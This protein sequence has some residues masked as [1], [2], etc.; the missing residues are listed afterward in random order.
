MQGDINSFNVLEVN[1]DDDLPDQFVE[2]ERSS[3]ASNG[4]RNPVQ[5]TNHERESEHDDLDGIS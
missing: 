5:D 4:F 1:A 3:T 2:S